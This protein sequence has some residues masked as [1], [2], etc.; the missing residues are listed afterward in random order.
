MT[1]GLSVWH[2]PCPYTRL[3]LHPGQPKAAFQ[4]SARVYFELDPTDPYTISALARPAAAVHGENSEDVLPRELYWRLKRHLDY[5]TDDAV[6]D[7]TCTAGQGALRRLPI[8]RHCG[9]LGAQEA[10]VGDA[11]GELGHRRPTFAAWCASA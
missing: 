1:P 10:G 6:M 4:A 7:D 8:Q 11:H 9:Q 3:G 2:H 5:E